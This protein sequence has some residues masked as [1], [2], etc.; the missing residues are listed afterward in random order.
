MIKYLNCN[1]APQAYKSKP[2][3]VEEIDEHTDSGRIWATILAIR[4]EAQQECRTA[5]ERGF[6]GEPYRGY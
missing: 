6:S 1:V 3:T 5:Y 4:L 2:L